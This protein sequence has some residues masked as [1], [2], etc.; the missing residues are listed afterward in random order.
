LSLKGKS[1]SSARLG[2]P[3]KEE[4]N[5][6]GESTERNVGLNVVAE[7]GDRG[8]D[9]EFENRCRRDEIERS[10]SLNFGRRPRRN[11]ERRRPKRGQ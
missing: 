4:R 1:R 11:L 8:H 5:S 3:E 7:F 2:E 9:G 10:W 6:L